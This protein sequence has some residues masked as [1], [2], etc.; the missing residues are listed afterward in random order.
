MEA[1]SISTKHPSTSDN[2]KYNNKSLLYFVDKN[3]HSPGFA[4]VGGLIINL[5][6]KALF[7]LQQS[8]AE[9]YHSEKYRKIFQA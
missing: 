5:K 6:H 4:T 3:P 8:R 7:D 1:N 9:M 2:S